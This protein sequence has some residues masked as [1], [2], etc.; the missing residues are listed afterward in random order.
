MIV[1]L[2]AGLL[3]FGRTLYLAVFVYTFLSTAFFLVSP[4]L[5]DLSL[6]IL[7]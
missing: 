2:I 3:G 6:P 5:L 4:C 7:N 1:T